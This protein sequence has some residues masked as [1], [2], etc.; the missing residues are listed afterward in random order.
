MTQASRIT[1]VAIVQLEDGSRATLTCTCGADGAE[2]L[3][4]NNRRV[5]TTS[6][7]KLIADDTG[8][9]LEV[10]GYLGTWRPSDAPARPA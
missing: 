8:A 1:D 7:G 6:D 3:L 10:V 4:V 9:E 5:S 2:E